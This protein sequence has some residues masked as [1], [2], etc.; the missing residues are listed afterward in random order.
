VKVTSL[1]KSWLADNKLVATADVDDDTCKAAA[2][3]AL[4]A[5]T[6]T[7]D[8]LVELTRDPDGDK[9]SSLEAL[10]T[11]LNS[12]LDGDKSAA[13]AGSGSPA[14]P[15]PEGDKGASYLEK[16]FSGSQPDDSFSGDIIRV[17]GA[18]E[19]YS[20]T[21]SALRYTTH[22]RKGV[23]RPMAGTPILEGDAE[24]GTLR[25]VADASELDH[26][27]A[28][29]YFKFMLYKMNGNQAPHQRLKMTDHEKDLLQYTLRNEKFGG[30]MFGG[31]DGMGRG[32]VEVYNRK[33]ADLEVKAL[34]DDSTSGGLE[35]APIV[36]DDAIIQIPLLYGELFPM[37]NVV[38]I[39]RGRRIEGGS[40]GTVTL[41]SGGADGT[42]IPLFSTASFIA[43]FDT[44]IFACNGAIE[45]GLDFMSDS[46]VD[47]GRMVTQQYGEVLLKWLDEQVAVGDGS[48][49]PEGIMNASGTTS[50]AFSSAA[51]TVAKY[52][53]LLFGVDKA[54]K[55]NTPMNRLAF[56]SNETS[57]LRARQIATGVTG[58]TRLVFGME[59]EDYMLFQHPYAINEAM[60]NVQIFFANMSRYRMYRRLGL[61]VKSTTEGKTLVR[62]NMLLISARARYGGQ[63]EDGAAAAVVTDAQ[64]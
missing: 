58:D 27:I 53:S 34:L 56:A 51:P 6:L 28:G 40:I 52:L 3:K 21:K 17:K 9:A 18:H 24:S 38:P 5:D 1:L 31:D 22:S 26:A 33:L 25:Q 29:A 32:A 60:S 14:A 39:T 37:V 55:K 12:K 45:I 36:F 7:A 42:D 64:A 19:S 35:I 41:T 63:L 23:P 61:T 49:E 8:K 50:V 48:T 4:L 11:K 57:Y 30:T 10:L 44:T 15:K 2:A 43:A 13:G 59:V 46:P 20:K 54:Y 16:I 47:I 62:Q